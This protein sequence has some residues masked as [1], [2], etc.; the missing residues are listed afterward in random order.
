[1]TIRS[2]TVTAHDTN[3]P[4]EI[5]IRGN[6]TDSEVEHLVDRLGRVVRPVAQRLMGIEAL[7]TVRHDRDPGAQ[8]RARVT[9]RGK[10]ETI[11]AE[12][13]TGTI[14]E[15]I[16]NIDARLHKQ[17]EQRTKRARNDPRGREPEAGE[18]RHG[19]LRSRPASR[20]DR[21]PEERDIVVRKSP[22]PTE[23][24]V[25]EARWDR[26]MLDYDFFLFVDADTGRDHL[27]VGGE[28]DDEDELLD[29]ADAPTMTLEQAEE[30]LD[31]TN[32]DFHF[33]VDA[34]SGRGAVIYWRYDGHYGLLMPSSAETAPVEHA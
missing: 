16:A 9:L 3:L 20:F 8:A 10:G 14:G 19:N 2:T 23:A 25:D 29:A 15:A 24:T 33:F 1:M 32:D 27:L 31:Q 17:L 30:W 13:Y 22:A 6:V 34:E 4:V 18:W 26:F 5:E 12:V 28:A 11:R 7:L 21:P